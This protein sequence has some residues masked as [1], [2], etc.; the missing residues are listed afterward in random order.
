MA[1]YRALRERGRV[2]KVKLWKGEKGGK[3]KQ[4]THKVTLPSFQMLFSFS[5]ASVDESVWSCARCGWVQVSPGSVGDVFRDRRAERVAPDL[6]HAARD[7]QEEQENAGDG[8]NHVHPHI[9]PVKE[10]KKQAD[11]SG[12][13]ALCSLKWG[14]TEEGCQTTKCKLMCDCVAMPWYGTCISASLYQL[15]SLFCA[16]SLQL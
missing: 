15:C 4:K 13:T 14:K 3:K 16:T 1:S 12:R 11:K 6:Q 5:Y 8:N 7:E 2:G 10:E 9:L